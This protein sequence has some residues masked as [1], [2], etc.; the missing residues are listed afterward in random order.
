MFDEKYGEC[1]ARSILPQ[2]RKKMKKRGKSKE[3]KIDIDHKKSQ[4]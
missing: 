4:E 1:L 3:K 2:K